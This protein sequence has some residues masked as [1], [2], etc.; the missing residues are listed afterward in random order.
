MAIVHITEDNFDEVVNSNDVVVIDF[1]A[2][3]CGPCK[4]FSPVFEATSAK[5]PDVVF[6]KVDTEEQ[7]ELARKFDIRS[8][9][10]LMV[11]REKV[12]L[13][14]KPGAV[15]ARSLETLVDKMLAVDMVQVR[16]EIASAQAEQSHS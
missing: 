1:W 5:Y 12:I 11:V 8:I 7:M 9:P 2:E 14:S 4:T 10:T 15:P 13:Y 3:W 6:G 16:D